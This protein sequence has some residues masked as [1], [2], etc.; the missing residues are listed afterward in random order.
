[1]SFLLP[2]AFWGLLAAPLLVTLYWWRRRYRP[3][4][5]GTLFLW[6]APSRQLSGGRRWSQLEHALLML[7]E[8]L[9]VALLA[10]AAAAPGCRWRRQ[11]QRVAVVL[12]DSASMAARI[13]QNG[14]SAAE[15]ASTWL[16]AEMAAARPF[17]CAL[18]LTGTAPQLVSTSLTNRQDLATALGS[19]QPRQPVHDFAPALRLARQTVGP[20]AQVLLL[21]DHAPPT[22]SADPA[23][24]WRAF[25]QPLGNVGMVA[26]TRETDLVGGRESITVEVVASGPVAG[27]RILECR[28]GGQLLIQRQLI[29]PA[30]GSVSREFRET[31][32]WDQLLAGAVEVRLVG[33]DALAE[34]DHLLL[35]PENRRPIRIQLILAEDQSALA[36]LCAQTIAALGSAVVT[37]TE[38]PHLVITD[39]R[40]ALPETLPAAAWRLIVTA[41]AGEPHR[42]FGPYVLAKR[43]P[44][45]NYLQLNGV[46]WVG[47]AQGLDDRE[48]VPLI[49]S[50]GVPLLG[51]RSGTGVGREFCLNFRPAGSSLQQTPAWPVLIH[52]LIQ[53]CADAQPGFRVHNLRAGQEAIY[54]ADPAAAP[55][56]EV[57]VREVSAAGQRLLHQGRFRGRRWSFAAPMP[58]LFAVTFAETPL[59][60]EMLACQ[61][62]CPEESDLCHAMTGEWNRPPALTRLS[63]GTWQDDAWRFLLVAVA[64]GM[65]HLYYATRRQGAA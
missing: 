14:S 5:V 51:E 58:G 59:T 41:G 11:L 55:E 49:S 33:A 24:Y 23:T 4:S 40:A 10:M 46:R 29:I 7:L 27:T 56:Q 34:D 21:T 2:W 61:L 30:D 64:V 54:Q 43:H 63:H 3:L 17:E 38:R 12:D 57:T 37:V 47:A 9:L 22:P 48:L 25:G 8:L 35:L 42:H 52:N 50:A 26:A 62:A 45:C 6:R 28:R 53:A 39:R 31:F 32:T 65:L 19:W 15:R 44:L 20:E 36:Q 13:G 18:I 60:P 1:M 16:Q